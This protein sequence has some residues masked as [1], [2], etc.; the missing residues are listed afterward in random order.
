MFFGFIFA[1]LA[2][3]FSDSYQK[4]ICICTPTECDPDN[5]MCQGHNLLDP[6][7]P[8]FPEDFDKERN[9]IRD[10][11][12]AFNNP[13]PEY[14]SAKIDMSMI[15]GF[16]ITI[17]PNYYLDLEID[18]DPS[19]NYS[20]TNIYAD[21]Y[22]VTLFFKPK[23]T[24]ASTKLFI[25]G[26]LFATVQTDVYFFNDNKSPLTV[27]YH[28]LN[29]PVPPIANISGFIQS[30]KGNETEFRF[31]SKDKIMSFDFNKAE[32]SLT[33]MDE[34]KTFKINK[35]SNLTFKS[36]GNPSFTDGVTVKLGDGVQYS[37]I[38][39]LFF[40]KNSHLRFEGNL[41]KPKDDSEL[42]D[43]FK[44]Y[45]VFV[46]CVNLPFNIISSSQTILTYKD[47]S[48][49][50]GTVVGEG[51]G[52]FLSMTI[53]PNVPNKE[54][55]IT[56][57]KN[58]SLIIN[59]S[60]PYVVANFKEYSPTKWED[61]FS[62]PLLFATDGV[63]TSR[64]VI[65]SYTFAQPSP[66][67]YYQ[68][69]FTVDVKKPLTD[70]A[71]QKLGIIGKSFID[72]PADALEER[73]YVFNV[74]QSSI[75][76]ILGIP[77]F[78]Q[79]NPCLLLSNKVVNQKRS[80][81][82]SGSKSAYEL[83]LYL[84]ITEYDYSDD[85]CRQPPGYEQYDPEDF[86]PY[87]FVAYDEHFDLKRYIPQEYK[88][89]IIGVKTP[90]TDIKFDFSTLNSLKDCDIT[91]Y[92]E[93]DNEYGDQVNFGIN[94]VKGQIKN[95]TISR[96]N[97]FEL[98]VSSP[99]LQLLKIKIAEGKMGNLAFDKE[100]NLTI[101]ILTCSSLS[102]LSTKLLPVRTNMNLVPI[103]YEYP[104]KS[105]IT[106]KSDRWVFA[107]ED[108]ESNAEIAYKFSDTVPRQ[109]TVFVGEPVE[110][111]LS[112]T[113]AE[114]LQGF[115]ITTVASHEIVMKESGW[116]NVKFSP[117][118]VIDHGKHILP[119]K[120]TQPYQIDYVTFVGDSLVDFSISYSGDANVC[121]SSPNSTQ[122]CD[123][124]KHIVASND[125]NLTSSLESLAKTKYELNF[126][127]G[128]TGTL[129]FSFL[130][131]KDVLLT[132]FPDSSKN[133]V[134][135]NFDTNK[136]NKIY[137]KTVFNN[138]K[139]N[140][141][142]ESAVSVEFGQLELV[143]VE[144]DPKW[145]TYV[146][147]SVAKLTCT[148][149]DLTNFK[150][151]LITDQ[152]NMNGDLPTKD[153]K[154]KFINDY[155]AND[156]IANL[157][158]D[159][160]INIH[161][162][163]FTL[164]KLE[165]EMTQSS[166]YDVFLHAESPLTI[167][168]NCDQGLNAEDI[169]RFNITSME[170]VDLI[171]SNPWPKLTSGASLVNLFT[172]DES[173]V[174]LNG[175]VPLSTQKQTT[176][177]FELMTK[178]CSI[179]GPVEHNVFASINYD[180]EIKERCPF[181]IEN[182]LFI[183]AASDEVS[184]ISFVQSPYID[185]SISKI[186]FNKDEI[187]EVNVTFGSA[188]G[189]DGVST[190]T[191]KDRIPKRVVIME[192]FPIRSLVTG[193]IKDEK[194]LPLL[195]K[196]QPIIIAT[197][198]SFNFRKSLVLK[199]NEEE[200]ENR[201]HGFYS[202][203]NCLMLNVSHPISGNKEIQIVRKLW[204]SEV[205]FKIDLFPGYDEGDGELLID[206]SNKADLAKLSE[207]IPDVI[208]KVIIKL[209]SDM[210]DTELKFS[211]FAK[212]HVIVSAPGNEQRVVKLELP[213]NS[214]LNVT[215]DNLKITFS[216]TSFKANS[217]NFT[218]CDFENPNLLKITNENV[219]SLVLDV[220][221]LNALINGKSLTTYNN[222]IQV[223]SAAYITFFEDGWEFREN[224]LKSTTHVK[225]TDFPQVSFHTDHPLYLILGEQTS[226]KVAGIAIDVT[227]DVDNIAYVTCGRGWENVIDDHNLIIST[228][229][230]KLAHITTS[231]YPI[232]GV[233]DT[234]IEFELAVDDKNKFDIINFENNYVINNKTTNFNMRNLLPQ[235]RTF[236]AQKL[237]FEGKSGFNFAYNIGD[238]EI[239]EMDVASKA[240]VTMS[241]ATIVEKLVL[242]ENSKAT[243]SFSFDKNAAAVL[244]WGI[245]SA[246][247]LFIANS[248][249]FPRNIEVRYEHSDVD[250]SKY[251]EVL[252]DG[253]GIVLM[254][255]EFDCSST[256]RGNIK[257]ISDYEY[258]NDEK[259][260]IALMCDV[261]TQGNVL[262]LYGFKAIPDS[263]SG[264]DD[265]KSE[266]KSGLSPG[267]TVGVVIACVVVVAIIVGLVIYIRM[268]VKIDT[269]KAQIPN[270]EQ[271]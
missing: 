257:F 170:K 7:S 86:S 245:E 80:V 136:V 216:G 105:S 62:F 152:L 6:T 82:F 177:N 123:D 47:K 116:N 63:T 133:E 256:L 16:N 51:Y 17:Q 107:S 202:N 121:V 40:F 31:N 110:I 19:V 38:P 223:F 236:H 226:K 260:I 99:N 28:N 131:Q 172:W 261:S 254:Q 103:H 220:D 187:T 5:E 98:N 209:Y 14:L 238:F 81:S 231:S 250:P 162:G 194:T 241:K 78:T 248:T 184:V 130:N 109:L 265:S 164:G 54:A 34:K 270:D 126:E 200:V 134:I 212:G 4:T 57:N 138:M 205:P 72:I 169:P 166:N 167:T 206:D 48:T 174:T 192:T 196:P 258:F 56:F 237:R 144:F 84:C 1:Q 158:T 263:D 183:Q 33:Y 253:N 135:I 70:A 243:G 90:D 140:L 255:G 92:G 168:F 88:Q 43:L 149:E 129:N 74:L 108:E 73:E 232:V 266:S 67:T 211:F 156:L 60:T 235:Y 53:I 215:F 213:N 25:I 197:T 165:V 87:F 269:L 180:T 148:Y 12:I 85:A 173:K 244:K 195:I 146:D 132:S 267:G 229:G 3:S 242:D 13:Y 262:V 46:D 89:I 101:D 29:I 97:L 218:D 10:I 224:K 142:P 106:I 36:N 23:D 118:I 163:H 32:T 247:L 68:F 127:S 198:D 49:I 9:S 207:F 111:K 201:A 228:N 143:D 227:P 175:Y 171:F 264:S 41:W 157:T 155:D 94:T 44:C 222:K 66:T 185:L 112:K 8:T 76:S 69:N 100:L 35:G 191:I 252:L 190:I 189:N 147:L 214:D 21:S 137:S 37:D 199:Y 15:A 208:N 154:V 18:Y 114:S 141:H 122:K 96:V 20:S 65:E 145:A 24:S 26:N 259:R 27:Y 181:T 83:P 55:T 91:I 210:A 75:S 115:N 203:S 161:K 268:K 79:G 240:D 102:A 128:T 271:L 95:L 22:L 77:G 104:V 42:I 119:F 186:D 176:L 113:K 234:K 204:P 139:L 230:A 251:N 239:K 219:K 93:N 125:E 246:P 61:P 150:S 188:I 39:K 124:S 50:Y 120:L 58:V 11:V 217:C 249:K 2:F 193:K 71:I 64:A 117:N 30:A 225:A 179:Y 160:T 59:M 159:V 233:F 153:V 178:D 182:G 151:I 45:D 221:S 52:D